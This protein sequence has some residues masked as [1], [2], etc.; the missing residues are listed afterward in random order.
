MSLAPFLGFAIYGFDFAREIPWWM[1]PFL[2]TSFLRSGVIALIIAVF[3][4]DRGMLNC[5]HPMYCHFRDPKV[6][7][8]YLDLDHVSAWAE[9]GLLILIMLTF[10]FACFVG[11]RWRLRT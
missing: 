6:T 2:K 8:H 4:M 9:I 7:I 10:R 11:L 5:H 3:G 1:W